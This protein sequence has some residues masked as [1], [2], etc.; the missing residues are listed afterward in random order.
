M[1]YFVR[2]FLVSMLFTSCASKMGKVLKSKDNEY[3]LKMAEQFYAQKKYNQAQQVFEDIMPYFRGSA[4]YED[5]F[6]KYSYCAY[7]QKDYLNAENLFKTYLDN[8]PNSARAEE[9][10]Y[11]HCYSFYKQSPKVDLD[12]TATSKTISLMQAFINTHPESSRNKEATEI[13]DDCRRK[14]EQ[15]EYKSA[16]LYYDLSYY[17]AAAVAFATLIDDYPDSEKGDEYKLASIKAYYKYAEM[18]V[19]EKQEERFSKVVTEC[20]DFSDRFPDSQL[21][22]EVASYKT[23]SENNIKKLQNEQTTQTSKR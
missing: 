9:I 18:S 10:D 17:K 21:K 12:Q 5:I 1:K 19:P 7:Y 11:M 22:T 3:K 20:S 6:Y 8:F 4:K 15:K 13:I 2:V 14:L 16:Q 23:L